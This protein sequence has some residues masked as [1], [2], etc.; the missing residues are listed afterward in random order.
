ML[1]DVEFNQEHAMNTTT[2]RPHTANQ[3]RVR[4]LEAQMNAMAR[5]WLY[6][7]SAVEIAGVDIKTMES[8]LRATHWD[9]HPEID[10]EGRAALHWL[11]DQLDTARAARQCTC[12]DDSLTLH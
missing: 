5:A 6:L 2:R 7:V 4:T 11:C 10:S 9:E 3:T 8:G 12:R 1:P